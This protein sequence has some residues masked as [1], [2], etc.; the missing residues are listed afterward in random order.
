MEAINKIS[1][2]GIGLFGIALITKDVYKFVEIWDKRHALEIL[3]IINNVFRDVNKGNQS[4]LLPADND[5]DNVFDDE[6]LDEWNEI[7]QVDK[8]FELIVDNLSL[9]QLQSSL[10]EEG[11]VS[12]ESLEAGVPSAGIEGLETMNLEH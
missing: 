8:L 11:H 5:D 9:S 2:I 4:H 1:W 6:L 7:L 12:H 3:S 10:L